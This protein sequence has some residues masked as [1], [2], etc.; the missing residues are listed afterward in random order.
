MAHKTYTTINP[1]HL[2][3]FRLHL[4][5]LSNT[6]IAST[7]GYTP[8]NISLILNST[9]M[10]EVCEELKEDILR[11]TY[12]D[13]QKTIDAVGPLLVEEKIRLAL[14]AKDERVRSIS[15]TEMLNMGGHK[16]ITHV[17]VE[18]THHEHVKL[19]ELD[20]KELRDRVRTA[21]GDIKEEKPLLV[22]V[23]GETLH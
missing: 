15:C 1:R 12:D 20:E 13:V 9:N 8:Q 14:T 23:I 16:P 5:G 19:S 17:V 6:E 2:I 22:D 11:A 10:A 18:E 4:K 7:L 21:I 3:V